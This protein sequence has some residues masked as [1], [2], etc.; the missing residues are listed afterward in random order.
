MR[1]K[2]SSVGTTKHYVEYP[3]RNNRGVISRINIETTPSLMETTGFQVGDIITPLSHA[4]GTAIGK[5]LV[6]G[7]SGGE[8][9]ITLWGIKAENDFAEAIDKL[10]T[11]IAG[12][13][14]A[15][16]Y[17][18]VSR[19]R[20]LAGFPLTR[21]SIRDLFR[22]KKALPAPTK[23]PV[24]MMKEGGKEMME[25][26]EAINAIM[27]ER[28][29]TEATEAIRSMMR[30]RLLIPVDVAP[31]GSQPLPPPPTPDPWSEVPLKKPE[32]NDNR[33]A[34]TAIE[35]NQDAVLILNTKVAINK[36]P[37]HPE[38]IPPLFAFE[39]F[40]H[41]APTL[42][43]LE[44]CATAVQLRLPCLLEGE[45]AA[46]KTSSIEYLA[47]LTKNPI[48]RLNL[49]GQ[50]DTSELIGKFVPNEGHLAVAFS[51]LLRNVGTLKPESKAIVEQA[52]KEGRGLSKLDSQ[53]IA[54]AEGL[55]VSDWR[56]KDGIIPHA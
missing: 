17:E 28:E 27:R 42:G 56:W 52:N 12:A 20:G 53:Q 23:T 5:V 15:S 49:N 9:F 7:A 18:L 25:A 22:S 16:S 4:T 46:S 32:V 24:A 54:N 26:M 47:S 8:R 44:K 48:F 35:Q 36:N 29:A 51:D 1:E 43:T 40:S 41:D 33:K 21:T 30:E 38:L 10:D 14:F 2:L 37:A 6:V 19:G 3:A 50:T 31:P 34:V 11:R 45:T 55:T 39:H 13:T